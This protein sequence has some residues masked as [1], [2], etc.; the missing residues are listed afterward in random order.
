MFKKILGAAVGL[1]LAAGLASAQTVVRSSDDS[2]RVLFKSDGGRWAFI[3]GNGAP[4]FSTFGSENVPE[5]TLYIDEDSGAVY[6]FSSSAWVASTASAG[7][8]TPGTTT[9]GSSTDCFAFADTSSVLR[10]DNTLAK[11]DNSGAGNGV[12]TARKSPSGGSTSSNFFSVAGTTPALT[13]QFRGATF[14]FTTAGSDAQIIRGLYSELVA[15][16]TTTQATNAIFASNGVAGTGT[17]LFTNATNA[18]IYGID[19]PTTAGT[20]V[21]V[22]GVAGGGNVN[23]GAYGRATL[24]KDSATNVGVLGLGG[25]GG[26]TP[27][28]VGGYFGLDAATPTFLEAALQV[29]NAAIAAP[30]ARFQDNGAAI[31]TT[32]ATASWTIADGAWPQLGNGVLTS[33][34]M[35]A[36]T[37]ARQ[38]SGLIHSYTWTNAQVVALGAATAGDITV[39]TLPAKTQV[40]NAYVVITGQGAGTTTLTVSCGDAVGGTPFINYVV[41]SDAQAAANTVYGDAVAERGTS[42][43]TEFWYLPSY[44]ATT[45]VTC[46]FISTGANLDQV[47][48]STGRVILETALLP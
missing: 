48:G 38:S 26:A 35:T 29:N 13:A 44:T 20:N 12:F 4:S 10:C 22:Q 41:A 6:Y 18:A 34:T 17:N 36:E 15:G 14:I 21:G 25:N 7:A 33:A 30:I 23:V 8:I 27:V 47:T 42:L 37:Q 40:K 1:L 28:R 46:H 5:D 43:D 9:V 24:N 19:T 2:G 11:L 39:A 16:S 32:G 31:P 3:R 45:L